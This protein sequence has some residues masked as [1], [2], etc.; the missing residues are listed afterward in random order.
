M[1]RGCQ[2]LDEGGQALS[3]LPA[4]LEKAKRYEAKQGMKRVSK[5]AA[6]S[7]GGGA[8]RITGH[9][10]AVSPAS[11]EPALW[12]QVV[13]I[14]ISLTSCVMLVNLSL[15]YLRIYR[16]NNTTH[17]QGCWGWSRSKCVKHLVPYTW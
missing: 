12:S 16:D 4:I 1:Y 13:W 8:P 17:S 9:L 6:G 15:S 14:Q 5:R 11:Q 2:L 10:G 3:S 7:V